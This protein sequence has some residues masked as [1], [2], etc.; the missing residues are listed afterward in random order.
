MRDLFRS[1][2]I[3]NINKSALF[4]KKKDKQE[5]CSDEE[6]EDNEEEITELLKDGFE[7]SNNEK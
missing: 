7:I 5:M 3:F 2:Q 4:T 1:N 6:S